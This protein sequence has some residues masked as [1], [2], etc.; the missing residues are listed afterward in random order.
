MKSIY[1]L[2]FFLFVLEMDAQVGDITRNP[3][4]EFQLERIV[5]NQNMNEFLLSEDAID[6]IVLATINEK[7][8]GLFQLELQLEHRR[9]GWMEELNLDFNLVN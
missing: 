5:F 1:I 3:L 6:S 7:L 8:H 9:M 2:L 4:K